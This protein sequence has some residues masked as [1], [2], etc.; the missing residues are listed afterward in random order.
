MLPTVAIPT[1]ILVGEEDQ[2][3]PVGYARFLAGQ[4][5]GA[6]LQV[7]PAAAHLPHRENP[8][9]FTSLLRSHLEGVQQQ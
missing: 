6:M 7:V 4:I 3:T 8:R 5:K 1:L 2:A 9:A